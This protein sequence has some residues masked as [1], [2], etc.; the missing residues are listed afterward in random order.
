MPVNN[1]YYSL[2]VFKLGIEAADVSLYLSVG[3]ILIQRLQKMVVA[4]ESG[5]ALQVFI[6]HQVP[7]ENVTK[8]AKKEETW[9]KLDHLCS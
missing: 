6:T 4:S 2:E 5:L 1:V 8:R 7:F 3:K 9:M